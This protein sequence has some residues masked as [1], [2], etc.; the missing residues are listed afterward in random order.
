MRAI[1]DEA[2]TRIA[3]LGEDE[4]RHLLVG[5]AV[6]HFLGDGKLN[7]DGVEFYLGE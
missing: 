3:G 5:L 2:D 4:F 6:T 7:F 1:D